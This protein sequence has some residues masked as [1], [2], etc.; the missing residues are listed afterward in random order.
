MIKSISYWSFKDGTSYTHPVEEAMREA[1]ATGFAGIELAIGLSGVL[2]TNTDETTCTSY[3]KAAQ[4]HGL[5]METCAAALT[6][7][8]SPTHPDAAV[9]KQSIELHAAALQRAA[10]LGC[11]AMLYVPGAVRI[12]WDSDYAPVR[13]DHAIAWAREGA[14]RLSDVAAKLKIQ[15]CLENVWNGMFYSP[16][17]FRDFVN[18][19]HSEWAGI[20]FDVGNIIALHQYPPHWIELLGGLIRRVHIKD[21]KK[22]VSTRSDFRDLGEGD[23][24]WSQTIAALR[25]IGYDRTIVAEMMPWDE[26]LLERTSRAMDR[27]LAS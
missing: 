26:G 15:L 7:T 10:W 17:E 14:L 13:Y 24:P 18:S 12:P 11:A 3:R 4:K 2:A 1:K 9:R 27:I 6:W 16:L 23:V 20:Y 5:A 21:Y 19:L 25:Q 22:S 8:C